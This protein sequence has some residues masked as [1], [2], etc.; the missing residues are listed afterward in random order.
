MSETKENVQ[1]AQNEQAALLEQLAKPEVQESL[2]N[3]VQ[4]LPKINEVLSSITAIHDFSKNLLTDEVFKSDMM[5]ATKEI[6]GPAIACVKTTALDVIEAKD[7]A[8][9]SNEE[10]GVFGLMKMLKD[11]QIQKALRFANAFLQVSNERANKK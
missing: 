1:V 5:S 11:P 10:I 9:L 6:V 7:R 4:N 8:A 3:L 2:N